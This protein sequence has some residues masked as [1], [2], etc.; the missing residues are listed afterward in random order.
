MVSTTLQ[1]Y[2]LRGMV[3]LVADHGR[4]LKESS[5][6]CWCAEGLFDWPGSALDTEVLGDD[7]FH[8]L[9]GSAINRLDARVDER[10]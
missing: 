9:G 6:H 5:T 10:A 3:F 1:K 4:G 2:T 8:D 7:R